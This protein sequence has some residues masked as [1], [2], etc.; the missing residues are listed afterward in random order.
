MAQKLFRYKGENTTGGQWVEG[1]TWAEVLDLDAKETATQEQKKMAPAIEQDVSQYN[2]STGRTGQQ[3]EQTQNVSQQEN[4]RIPRATRSNWGDAISS[5]FDDIASSNENTSELESVLGNIPAPEQR[6]GGVS[7]TLQADQYETPTQPT[8]AYRGMLKGLPQEMVDDILLTYER[9]KLADPA[10]AANKLASEVQKARATMAKLKNLDNE[11][12]IKT[13]YAIKKDEP[14]YESAEKIAFG[15]QSGATER[16]KFEQE[17]ANYR[18]RL[19]AS[20]NSAA[21]GLSDAD[22]LAAYNL[23]TEIAGKRPGS[24]KMVYPTIINRLKSGE[25]IN[26]IRDSLRYSQQSED[27][28]GNARLAIQQIYSGKV[29]QQTYDSFDDVLALGDNNKTFD[30]L[31]QTARKN[32]DAS[33]RSQ[34]MGEERTIGFLSEIQDDLNV[35]EQNG[36]NTNIFT[37]TT[38][39]IAKKIG[40]VNNAELRGIATKIKTALMR[41]RKAMTG[42]AFTGAETKEYN[43]IFPS[44]SKTSKFNST[45]IGSLLDAFSG[46]VDYFYSSMMGEDIYNSFKSGGGFKENNISNQTQSPSSQANQPTQPQSGTIED[47]YRFKGGDPSDP[48]NWEQVQ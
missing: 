41:Y 19:A 9:E 22:N 6:R 23:A 1:L 36:G 28:V 10:K 20:S 7:A 48:N 24:I 18:A 3:Q 34:I 39:Q 17:Q 13:K 45:T 47:G 26:D 32:T 29:P 16:T 35:F 25:S 27:M 11:E 46:D 4:A 40:T 44:I 8:G 30:F 31:K 5:G 15:V 38:E 43:D 21:T 2:Q 14:G 37:G 42:L 12:A 33:Y